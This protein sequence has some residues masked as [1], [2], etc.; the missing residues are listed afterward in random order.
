MNLKNGQTFGISDVARRTGLNQSTIRMWEA[1]YQAVKPFRTQTNRRLYREQDIERFI[2]LRSLT[3][4]GNSISSIANLELDDL[5]ERLIGDEMATPVPGVRNRVLTVGAG[6][7]EVVTSERV[8]ELEIIG[9]FGSCS[10]ASEQPDLKTDLMVVGLE[11]LFPELVAEVRQLIQ[12][13]GAERSIVVYHFASTKTATALARAI[14]GLILF[15][16]PVG[17]GSITPGVFGSVECLECNRSGR[18]N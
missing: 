18:A 2:L 12:H 1:R 15:K 4:K 3:Q 8:P 5:R 11:T 13:T 14:P 7:G 16:A 9:H 17:G 6:V 10:L